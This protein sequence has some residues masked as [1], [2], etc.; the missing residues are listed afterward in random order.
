M[1]VPNA[2]CCNP[3]PSV[4]ENEASEFL[5]EDCLAQYR[6]QMN[7]NKRRRVMTNLNLYDPGGFVANV[8][9][10]DERPLPLPPRSVVRNE[11]HSY[12]EIEGAPKGARNDPQYADGAFSEISIVDDPRPGLF[13]DARGEDTNADTYGDLS[14]AEQAKRRAKLR[15]ML[16]AAL[17]EDPDD[18]TLRQ[19]LSLLDEP[20][21]AVENLRPIPGCPLT[22]PLSLED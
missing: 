9:P 15:A 21:N 1:F 3:P 13:G 10:V 22:S 20:K 4:G 7:L 11:K 6:R 5:C 8:E 18:A 12:D 14:E 16:D 17:A 19:A 2:A